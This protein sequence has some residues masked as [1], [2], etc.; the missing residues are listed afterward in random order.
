MS[1]PS[2]LS[3]D[4]LAEPVPAGG[5]ERSATCHP[6]ADAFGPAVTKV[7]PLRRARFGSVAREVPR[8]L[9]VTMDLQ[10]PIDSLRLIKS[11]LEAY[12]W[13]YPVED[14]RRCNERYQ[15]GYWVRQV[16]DRTAAL[17]SILLHKGTARLLVSG[18]TA[19]EAEA[20]HS[21][22]AV[23]DE[24]IRED[25]SF[26]EVAHKVVAIL[27]AADRIG[28]R[29]AGGFACTGPFVGDALQ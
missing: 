10:A 27:G 21:A 9:D 11:D 14:E 20:L 18:M 1:E 19:A 26:R 17:E 22:A 23:L 15:I 8:M 12:F 4:F 13:D 28:L 24:W 16:S 2:D 3:D 5:V 25:E 6:A 7:V 29:A